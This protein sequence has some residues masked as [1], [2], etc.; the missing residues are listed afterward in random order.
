MADIAADRIEEPVDLALGMMEAPGAGPAVRAA[1]DRLV[2]V[3]GDRSLQRR[4]HQVEG[5]IPRH[6]D[7]RIDT[8]QF[9]PGTRSVGEHTASDSG[10]REPGA[11][12]V[13]REH[14]VADRGR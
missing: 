6:L 14:P 8:A 3:L 12:A 11:A 1:E 4:G 10:P 5:P 2:A 13:G 7:E 9:A